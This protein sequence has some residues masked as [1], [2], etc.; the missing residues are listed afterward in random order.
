LNAARSA[1]ALLRKRDV[2]AHSVL[3]QR[4]VVLHL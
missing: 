3:D 2:K 1:F 4:D